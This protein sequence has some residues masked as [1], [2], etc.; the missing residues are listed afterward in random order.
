[1]E[2]KKSLDQRK[3]EHILVCDQCALS[4]DLATSKTNN[5]TGI[6]YYRVEKQKLDKQGY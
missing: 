4:A 5:G 6:K 3:T 2:W 1:M